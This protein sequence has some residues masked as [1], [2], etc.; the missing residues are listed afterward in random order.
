M[1]SQSTGKDTDMAP[2][3]LGAVLL[4]VGAFLAAGEARACAYERKNIGPILALLGVGFLVGAGIDTL[5]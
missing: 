2:F 4:V 1:S 5:L 3:S